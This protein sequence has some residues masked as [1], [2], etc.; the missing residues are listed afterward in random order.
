MEV[1]RV[2]MG[3]IILPFRVADSHCLRIEEI[4]NLSSWNTHLITYS[5]P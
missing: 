2:I 4:T 5:Q 3:I 1:G